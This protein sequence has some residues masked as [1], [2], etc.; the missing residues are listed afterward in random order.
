VNAGFQL[1]AGNHDLVERLPY[2]YPS[3]GDVVPHRLGNLV[4]D[5][6]ARR[7][8]LLLAQPGFAAADQ[9]PNRLT[10]FRVH[11]LSPAL[12]HDRRPT[13]TPGRSMGEL[14]PARLLAPTTTGRR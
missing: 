9:L 10:R 5:K 14:G 13:A 2:G 3:P 7:A 8:D 6:R 4:A 11:K 1:P 12:Y